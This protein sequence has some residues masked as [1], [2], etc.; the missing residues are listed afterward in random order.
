MA[1]RSGAVF[2]QVGQCG[3]ANLPAVR[4]GD[5][6]DRK[7]PRIEAKAIIR[8]EATGIVSQRPAFLSTRR[9]VDSLDIEQA[10]RARK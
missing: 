6:P 4:L 10:Q 5:E 3:C 1:A 2:Q 8:N 7:S 9:I